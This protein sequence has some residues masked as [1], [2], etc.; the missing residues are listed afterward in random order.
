MA[1]TRFFKKNLEA[2]KN[3]SPALVSALKKAPPLPA[4]QILPARS[5]EPVPVINRGG[6]PCYL[7]SRFNPESEGLR[8]A[9]AAKGGFTVVFGLGG[10]YHIRPLLRRTELTGLLIVDEN[11][12]FLRSILEGMDFSDIFSDPR[13]HVLVDA[14][15]ME[16]RRFLLQTY[17]PVLYGNMETLVLRSR[18][19]LN[20]QWF[21][22]AYEAL[23]DLP[24]VLG[25]DYTTQKRFGK[26]WF[27]NTLANLARSEKCAVP[28]DI[29]LRPHRRVLVTA[30]GPSLEEQ[31]PK[32][33]KLQSEGALLLA[34]DT[35]LPVLLASQ[36]TPDWVLSIDC[37]TVS[38]HHFLKGLP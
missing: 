6:R 32:I 21:T 14:S 29:F 17:I 13:V 16:I 19:D 9:G 24:E 33:R 38:Y 37:Q 22:R 15:P 7:H 26:R 20:P 30:A 11:I 18:R 12:S 1:D 34:A 36:I 27:M 3:S 25:R 8:T 5:G 4:L 31:L 28:P 10:A 23:K 2:L 35:S